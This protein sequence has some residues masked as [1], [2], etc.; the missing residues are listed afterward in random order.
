MIGYLTTPAENTGVTLTEFWAWVRYL[1]AITTDDKDLK[2][3]KS[4]AQLDAHQKT[5]LS[6]DFGMGVSMLW[7][8][9]KFNL[10]IVVDGRYFMEHYAALLDVEQRRTAKRGP[11][12]TPDFVA[13]DAAGLWH[14]IECKGTQSGIEYRERQLKAGVAQKQ[15]LLFPKGHVGQRLVCGLDIGIEGSNSSHLKVIDPPPD[16]PVTIGLENL[17]KAVD[18]ATRGVMSKALRMA[19]FE[20]SAEVMGASVV[21]WPTLELD[22]ERQEQP[23]EARLKKRAALAEAELSE[24]EN[25]VHL[26]D[27]AFIGRETKLQLPRRIRAGEKLVSSVTIRQGV[28][29]DALSELAELAAS[30]EQDGTFKADWPHFIGRNSTS[31]EDNEAMLKIGK[32]FRSEI[33]LQS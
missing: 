2:V 5:I 13:R 31:W 24:R 20:T 32:L 15:S 8:T 19:G 1:A 26:F 7:L 23:D 10:D 29:R 17:P 11:N 6:D 30:G 21:I 25:H 22:P 9:K 3:T 4:F 28:N 14:V 33:I 27:D 12:K 16:D 18:A